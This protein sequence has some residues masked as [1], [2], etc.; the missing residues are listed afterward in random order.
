[1]EIGGGIGAGVG[2][3]VTGADS[4]VLQPAT[5][6]SETT[7]LARNDQVLIL[8]L[9][10]TGALLRKDRNPRHGKMCPA[11][12]ADRRSW[13]VVL[14]TVGATVLPHPVTATDYRSI[15]PASATALSPA[16]D[17]RLS[18]PSIFPTARGPASSRSRARLDP[19]PMAPGHPRETV[20]PPTGRPTIQR[21]DIETGFRV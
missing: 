16:L 17:A 8:N 10:L 6:T 4:S 20:P 11:P 12:P 21:R 2:P 3:G 19:R 14:K 13:T 9:I 1:R 18:A 7:R 15:A 5:I